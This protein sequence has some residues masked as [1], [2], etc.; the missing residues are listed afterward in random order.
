MVE[1][2]FGTFPCKKLTRNT[3]KNWRTLVPIVIR[4]A[5]SEVNGFHFT[6]KPSDMYDTPRNREPWLTSWYFTQQ[7]QTI[8]WLRY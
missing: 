6:A 5:T 2:N 8:N 7:K 1:V 4:P 3:G